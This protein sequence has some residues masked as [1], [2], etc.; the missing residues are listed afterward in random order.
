MSNTANGNWTKEPILE[1]NIL[2]SKY[3]TEKINANK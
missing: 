2:L 1:D 3:L